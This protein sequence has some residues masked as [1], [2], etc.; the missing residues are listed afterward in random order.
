MSA[1]ETNEGAWQKRGYDGLFDRRRG[2][3]LIKTSADGIRQ[4]GVQELLRLYQEEY[5]N[6]SFKVFH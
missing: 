1:N 5:Y 6:F 2:K 3:T 4:A